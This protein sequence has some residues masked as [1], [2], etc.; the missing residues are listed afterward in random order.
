MGDVDDDTQP[1]AAP[2]D[3]NSEI[4]QTAMDRRFC[5]NITQFVHAI[6]RQLQMPQRPFGVGFVTRST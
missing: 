3:V 5:L 2:N 6:V 4:G 1:I